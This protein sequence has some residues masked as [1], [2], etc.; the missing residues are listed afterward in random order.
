[1]NDPFRSPLYLL[2][3]A[4]ILFLPACQDASTPGAPDAEP[5]TNIFAP[6]KG[7]DSTVLFVGGQQLGDVLLREKMEVLVQQYGHPLREDAAMGRSMAT[8]AIPDGDSMAELTTGSTRFMPPDSTDFRVQFV[9][10]TAR[11]YRSPEGLGVG[12]TRTEVEHSY[13]LTRLGSFMEGARDYEVFDSARGVGFEVGGD[14]IVHGIVV[15]D[16][17][18]SAYDS[19]L[20]LYEGF[21]PVVSDTLR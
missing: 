11:K 7:D 16:L 9:R 20:P 4:G 13:A 2:A 17:G 3:L 1:M 21:I 12:S 14:S 19:R 18:Q 10:T 8:F 5:G 6:S 15:H